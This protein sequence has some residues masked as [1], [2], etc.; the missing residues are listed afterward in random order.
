MLFDLHKII[1]K[2]VRKIVLF[3]E[4]TIFVLKSEEKKL[5]IILS[6]VTSS[7]NTGIPQISVCC[8]GRGDL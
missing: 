7:M 4:N 2:S 3:V 8:G 1:M 5:K 6:F